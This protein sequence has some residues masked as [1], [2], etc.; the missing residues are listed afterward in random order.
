MHFPGYKALFVDMIAYVLQQTCGVGIIFFLFKYGWT[1]TQ[2]IAFTFP[3]LYQEWKCLPRKSGIVRFLR[4]SKE[5]WEGCILSSWGI[6]SQSERILSGPPRARLIYDCSLDDPAKSSYLEFH[7]K[8]PDS[9]LHPFLCSEMHP[10]PFLSSAQLLPI[11]PDRS[12]I[13]SFW[14]ACLFLYQ[15]WNKEPFSVDHLA[16]DGP[17]KTSHKETLTSKCSSGKKIRRFYLIFLTSR[18]FTGPYWI[19]MF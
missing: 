19:T 16:R 15:N 8:I 14:M 5:V 2:R 1:K 11:F 7:R 9:F 12:D 4:I 17:T 10:G 13:S 6:W 3:K 18:T